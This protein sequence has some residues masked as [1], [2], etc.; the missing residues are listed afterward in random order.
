MSDQV[1]AER[2]E[3]IEPM[4]CDTRLGQ[5]R[6]G[7]SDTLITPH[8]VVMLRQVALV[9][10][11]REQHWLRQTDYLRQAARC[12]A[13]LCGR[14]SVVRSQVGGAKQ[15]P[16]ANASGFVLAPPAGLEQKGER[17]QTP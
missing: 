6:S 10:L 1:R 4:L 5:A 7:T 14:V 9:A 15:K 8:H 13:G 11:G 12:A 16:E 2:G 3:S 17:K